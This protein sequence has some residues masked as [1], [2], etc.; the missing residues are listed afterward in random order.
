MRSIELDISKVEFSQNDIRIGIRT[1][2]ILTNDLCY[3]TGT[4]IGDGHISCYRRIDGTLYMVTYSGDLKNEYDF[5]KTVLIPI[6][7]SLYNKSL[8]PYES[9]K[10][11]IQLVIKSKAITTFKLNSL[12]L[13]N[14]RK[15]GRIQIP[16]IIMESDLEFQKSCL[17]G[18]V[19]TDFSLVFRHE[20]YPKI[21]GEFVSTNR[22]LKTQ[23]LE[24]L[25]NIGIKYTCCDTK[26]LDKRNN[27]YTRKTAFYS[28]KKKKKTCYRNLSA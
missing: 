5:Y 2:Q 11:T 8:S 23:I 28:R 19:D 18:I 1:P 27:K 22:I 13:S 24:I 4:H 14:G 9:T 17:G 21:T 12:G 3:E 10:N 20:K 6:I 25:E 16:K 15:N 7:K 26:N